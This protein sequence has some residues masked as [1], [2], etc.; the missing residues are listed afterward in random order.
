MKFP[1]FE[2]L[3]PDSDPQTTS[4]KLIHGEF[5]G[6]SPWNF[7]FLNFWPQ[8]LTS[9]PL[10]LS[11]Y[12]VN[13]MGEAHEIP[14]LNLK[15]RF[16]PLLLL[17]LL[18]LTFLMRGAKHLSQRPSGLCAF[19]LWKISIQPTISSLTTVSMRAGSRYALYF[20]VHFISQMVKFSSENVRSVAEP[21][22][23]GFSPFEIWN[24]R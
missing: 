11:L 1:F 2:L 12:I 19:T 10:H 9:R 17:L 22:S 14:F 18:R 20:N 4:S 3:T 15:P 13:F 24:E 6:R 5:H 7:N 21:F 16:W 23:D 8:I